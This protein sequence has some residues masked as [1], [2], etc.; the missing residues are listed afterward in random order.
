MFCFKQTRCLIAAAILCAVPT[1]SDGVAQTSIIAATVDGIVTDT[2][3]AVLR[4]VPVRARLLPTNQVWTAESDGAGGF[5]FPRLPAGRYRFEAQLAD[6]EPWQRE[7]ELTVG[8]R[9]SLICRL[10][11]AGQSQSISVSDEKALISTSSTV[12][13][14][15]IDQRAVDSLPLNGRNF[16]SLAL[17]VPGVSVTN[18]GSNER[19]A[20]TSAVPGTGISFS[21]QR[22]ISNSFLLD[23]L[24]NN[25]DAAGLTG[26]F[27]SQEVIRE[28]QVLTN[29][30]QAEFGRT[31]GGVL[32]VLTR[33]GGNDWHGNLYGF[34]RSKHLDARNPLATR[35]D[36]FT[37]A[38]YGSS[39]SGPLTRDR[40]FFFANFE[41]A[42]QQRAGFITILPSNA[43]AINRRLDDVAYP[44]ERVTTGEFPTGFVTTNLFGKID[45]Q[46][47][48]RHSLALRYN[49]YDI[50]SPNARAV[51]GLR[52]LSQ[53]TAILNRDQTGAVI[54]TSQLSSS[55]VNE[56][57]ALFT[58]A[59]FAL[60]INDPV[61]PAV[62][63]SG[64][65]NFGTA[66]FSPNRR[67]LDTFQW[68]DSFSQHRGRHTFKF[69]GELL[70]SRATID[71]AVAKVGSYS[72]SSLAN[73]RAGRY[74]NYTQSFGES[75]L[76]Q[77]NPNWAAFAQDEWKVGRNVTLN[78]GM[79]YE[80][81]LLPQGIHR[82]LNNFAPRFG[83]AY[84]PGSTS[85]MVI[86]GNYGLF[87]DRVL[88]RATS[89]G[90][91][92]DG[93]RFRAAV[94]P[95]GVAGAPVFPGL[96]SS[97]PE[98]ILTSRNSIAPDLANPYTQQA[99]LE[100]ERALRPGMTLTGSYRY[101]HGVKLTRLRNLNVPTLSAAEATRLGVPNLGRPDPTIGN[102]GQYENSGNSVYHGMGVAL[103]QRFRRGTQFLVSYTLS[104]A[105][106]DVANFFFSSPQN[107]FDLRD[108]RSL[109]SNDQRHRFV[110]S[111]TS[112]LPE[113]G[114]RWQPLLGGF[115]LSYILSYGS[116]QPFNVQ[117]GNDRNNDTNVNDRPVGV[118]RNTGRGFASATLDLRLSRRIQWEPVQ[119]EFLVE[120]FNALNHTNLQFPNGIF[121]TGT[122]PLPTFGQA[123][124]AGD[125][126]QIQ[127]GLKVS[128]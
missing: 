8:Q 17:L 56:F 112:Q 14:S 35:K 57:R 97:F 73:F 110:L 96:L 72:F 70:Y 15:T 25:D 21:A 41:Q 5:L 49:F 124:G 69:G 95:F 94:V 119:L 89:N 74:I 92:R 62:S 122:Q 26:A 66:T 61:G 125:P 87:Y 4:D 33:S 3:G 107:N 123:T 115:Q 48:P 22:N 6:F 100:I 86:R 82:D 38:Q 78:F 10:T 105:I 108:E 52:A 54:V 121:G 12:L 40:N 31:T 58:R 2:T 20:E 114:G 53:G 39:L 1:V 120:S 24:T 23:G 90:L 16:L 59:R 65:A 30:G 106:D 28:F 68:T 34:L 84:A 47:T 111:G 7:I 29:G 118:G 51:G 127:F 76:F 88:L 128:F 71:F 11:V 37:Q 80:V 67:D 63:I 75:S 101:L 91:L 19:F 43:E 117:T 60:G 93:K 45:S 83:F 18:T 81:E 44:G 79:R 55:A 85:A 116:A 50:D 77:S 9:F 32:N 104:K 46:L 36:S 64:V 27:V 42:R 102:N 13:E 103:R 98:G 113:P 99:T 126:R 109:S